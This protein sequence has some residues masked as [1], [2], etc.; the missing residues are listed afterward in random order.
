MDDSQDATRISREL[1]IKVAAAFEFDSRI[2]RI[3]R[4]YSTSFLQIPTD[5]VRRGSPPRSILAG[6]LKTLSH[7][8][9][10]SRP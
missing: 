2:V 7:N 1:K 5:G 3:I 8:L 4:N 9:G 10:V 6:T